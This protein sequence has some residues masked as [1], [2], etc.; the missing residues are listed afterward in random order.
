MN[1]YDQEEK[2]SNVGRLITKLLNDE[3]D[4]DS[5]L[6]SPTSFMSIL[7]NIIANRYNNLLMSFEHV[8][9][10]SDLTNS[11]DK[12]DSSYK[13]LL[14][15]VVRQTTE[16]LM[17][18]CRKVLIDKDLSIIDSLSQSAKETD[19]SRG[20]EIDEKAYLIKKSIKD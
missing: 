10:E 13:Y 17:P 12:L 7:S 5:S 3:I 6:G 19:P 16:D 15:E 18:I 11:L 1:S 8:Y 14:K 4:K 2:A 20:D 9:D